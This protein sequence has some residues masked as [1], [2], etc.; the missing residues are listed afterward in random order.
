M[1]YP[2]GSGERLPSSRLFRL[3]TGFLG[4]AG[5]Y[6]TAFYLQALSDLIFEAFARSSEIVLLAP[7]LVRLT[8]ELGIA[9]SQL[10]PKVSPFSLKQ[11][12]GNGLR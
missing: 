6:L 10:L 12:R 4:F 3:F 2:Q 9:C 1:R 11:R 8:C 5:G 7:Q